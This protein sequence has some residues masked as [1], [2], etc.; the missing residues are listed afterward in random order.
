M[1]FLDPFGEIRPCN[2]MARDDKA[3][4]MGNLNEESFAHIWNSSQAQKLRERVKTCPRNC[5]MIG[6]AAPAM[7]RN[8]VTPTIWVVRNKMNSIWAKQWVP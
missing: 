3:S 6:T 2:G 7:K 8:I 1:F 4:S 5:W